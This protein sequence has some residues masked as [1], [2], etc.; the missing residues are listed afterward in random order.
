VQLCRHLDH[1][2]RIVPRRSLIFVV[3]DF[4]SA[5]GWDAA[6]ARLALRHEVVAVRLSDPLE[7]ELPDIG[8][9]LLQD[10]ESGE[11]LFV[12]THDRSFRKRFAELATQREETLRDSLAA[13]GVDALELSTDSDLLDALLRFAEL[14]E[15]RSR[16]ASGGGMPTH[17][18]ARQAAEAGWP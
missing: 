1:A 9:L 5:P 3:S 4:I 14:R 10:A 2:A 15:L 8:M 11:Q 17:L 7:H 13:A 6:L 12:D 16:A 18:E